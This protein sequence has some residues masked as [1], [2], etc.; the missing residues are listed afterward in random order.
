MSPR[1][2]HCYVPP[3]ISHTQQLQ[4][5]RF[6]SILNKTV[7]LQAERMGTCSLQALTAPIAPPMG[8]S[9]RDPPLAARLLRVPLRLFFPGLLP[10]G[11]GKAKGEGLVVGPFLSQDGGGAS[12][13]SFGP[14]RSPRA[15]PAGGRPLPTPPADAVLN[16]PSPGTVLH[17]EDAV[18]HEEK[19]SLCV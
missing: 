1:S 5:V 3:H 2:L 16:A 12:S 9:P 13:P 15:S 11:A 7:H 4:A 19:G 18:P 8:A 17:V 10:G 6:P 14:N